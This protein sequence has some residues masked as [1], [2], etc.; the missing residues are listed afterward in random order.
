MRKYFLLLTLL[1]LFS[2][3]FSQPSLTVNDAP[4]KV[5]V[6]DKYEVSF[7]LR[8]YDNP[9]DPEVINV[10]ADFTAPDGRTFRVIGFYYEGFN[11][12]EETKVEVATRQRDMDCWKIRFTPDMPGPW[13]FVI[14]AVDQNG[15]SY[16]D[17]LAFDCQTKVDA[18]GFIRAANNQFLKREVMANGVRSERSFF[19]VG[20]NVAWYSTADYN[21][22]KKP[23][24]IYDYK[25]YID[26]LAGNANYMRVWSCRYQYLSLIGPE[27]ANR[28]ND[29][30]V[31]Y[32][33]SKLNQK[34][35][36]ELDYI[37][38]YAAE[39]GINLMLCLFSYGELR[40]D[41]EALAESEK[42]GSMPSGWR[43]NPY[44]TILGLEQPGEFFS[45]PK[46]MRVT[47][48]LVRYYVARWGYATNIVCWELHNEVANAFKNYPSQGNE[49]D[50]VVNWHKELANFIRTIDPYNH[51]VS[52]SIGNDS[53]LPGILESIYEDLDIVQDHNYQNLQKAKS[54]DQ[55]SHI[56]FNKANEMRELYP[57]K[58]CFMG[59]YGLTSNDSGI[60]NSTK[61]PMGVDLHNSQWSSLFSGSIGSASFWFWKDLR[62]REVFNRF[63]PMMVFANSLPVLSGTYTA[64]TTGKVSGNNLVFSNSIETYYL[65]NATQD[66]LIGWCQD[67]AFAYQALRHLTD[68]VSEKNHFAND[69]VFDPEG[70]IYTLDP[71]KRPAPSSLSNRIVLPIENQRAGTV[72]VVRWFDPETGRELRSETAEAVV[73]RSWFRGKRIVIDFPASIRNIIGRRINNT[74]GDAVFMITKED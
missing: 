4:N 74:Y 35:A 62:Q 12:R 26:A 23:Y 19:P 42:Y 48:N 30:P 6:Y 43:Y 46:A 50:A 54:K 13:T 58:P 52:T 25:Y 32:F 60:S 66:T 1:G 38:S 27:H 55:M 18:N 20:P 72:Y 36:A 2:T 47:R 9:Y 57:E 16:C 61:D 51:L 69:G 3:S 40:D 44:H 22:F 14:H 49:T 21:K 33:D 53:Y 39:N 24:G 15:E 65:V 63:R 17:G 34:D 37:V 68:R 31:M 10:Y 41:S 11:F 45:D 64:A 7:T 59:E 8:H 28:E 67:G 73:R 5:S 56:L 70:Y 71:A 29:K